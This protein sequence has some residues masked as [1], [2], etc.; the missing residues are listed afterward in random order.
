MT[1]YINDF[2]EYFGYLDMATQD[3][4]IEFSADVDGAYDRE[5]EEWDEDRIRELAEKQLHDAFGPSAKIVWG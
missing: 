4:E 5:L 1:F 2:S 3:G